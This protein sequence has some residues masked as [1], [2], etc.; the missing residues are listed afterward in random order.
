MPRR[1]FTIDV[2]HTLGGKMLSTRIWPN[3]KPL[4]L[5]VLL[6]LA[7]VLPVSCA[8]S[9]D[10]GQSDTGTGMPVRGDVA[11][12]PASGAQRAVVGSG[13]P[14]E[15][16]PGAAVPPEDF[17]RK[18]VKTAE[19]GV[20][21]ES[22]RGEAAAA[23]QV[24]T[25]FGGTIIS[26]QTYR[27]DNAVYADLVL[28]VPS[29]HFE[30][31]LDELRGLGEEVTTDTV[32]GQ[33]V[34]EEYVDLHSRERNLLAAEQSL[35]DLYNRADDVQDA[36]SIQREL[37]AVRGQIEQVQGRM[38]YLKQSSDMSQISLNIQPVT[39]SP[40]P[41]PAWDP[42]VV[43]AKAWNASLA[44]LQALTA[45]ILSTLV[46]GWWIIPPLALGAWWL[47]RRLRRPAFAPQ[48]SEPE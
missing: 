44:V 43:V 23:E 27:S 36:L 29:E 34:T 22:V 7:L 9:G 17:D 47:R 13:A 3:R 16:V 8:K 30:D 32:S 37:T 19:L 4:T 6:L 46:F 15:A 41:P 24:A 26:S 35:L 21:S 39:S 25:R 38:Q 42:A 1:V 18:I 48:P 28:S 40:K 45:A 2:N 10:E 12:K 20:T 33:D 31:A 5:G 14:D 11:S